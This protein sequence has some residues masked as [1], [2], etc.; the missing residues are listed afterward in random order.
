[1]SN[2]G[3]YQTMTTIS[4]KVGGPYNLA[5]ILVGAGVAFG[6]V[7]TNGA[8][9]ISDKV[10]EKK[11]IGRKDIVEYTV[12]KEATTNEGIKLKKG[13]KFNVLERDGDAVLVNILD[14]DNNPYFVSLNL[15]KSV[16]NYNG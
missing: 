1:M 11:K 4:K 2:L 14:I 3:A 15:L 13:Y 9:F 10:K 16:S 8:R 12:F 6:V 7:A 5:G